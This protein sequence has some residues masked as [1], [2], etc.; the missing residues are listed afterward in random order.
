VSPIGWF[1]H[2]IF[3]SQCSTKDIC[4]SSRLVPT[5]KYKYK[6]FW[7]YPVRVYKLNF[8][9]RDL[10]LQSIIVSNLVND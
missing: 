2:N 4:V 8:M 3:L 6:L 7:F 5:T 9:Y 1:L 10:N